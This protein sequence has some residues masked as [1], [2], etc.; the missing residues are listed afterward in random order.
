[1]DRSSSGCL[2]PDQQADYCEVLRLDGDNEGL[3]VIFARGFDARASLE[4][5]IPYFQVGAHDGVLGKKRGVIIYNL[6]IQFISQQQTS[7]S[8][9]LAM[10]GQLDRE[11]SCAGYDICLGHPLEP[12]SSIGGRIVS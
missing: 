3:V 7:A 1:M 6:E 8:P 10:S 12:L 2:P 9:A 11:A 5:N 4:K